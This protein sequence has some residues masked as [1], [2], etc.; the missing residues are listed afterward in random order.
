MYYVIIL[1]PSEPVSKKKK[2]FV[3]NSVKL[4]RL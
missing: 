3:T 4:F 1:V 2:D